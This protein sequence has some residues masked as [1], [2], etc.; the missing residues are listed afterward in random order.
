[1]KTKFAQMEI[2]LLRQS[3]HSTLSNFPNGIEPKRGPGRPRKEPIANISGEQQITTNNM[4]DD[5]NDEN[6]FNM[7]VQEEYEMEMTKNEPTE[8]DK[9]NEQ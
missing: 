3:K 4:T 1:M 9:P 7:P 8:L 6:D 2:G 5:E